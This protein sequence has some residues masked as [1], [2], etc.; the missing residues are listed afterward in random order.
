MD[1]QPLQTNFLE[2][3]QG[4]Y[5]AVIVIIE[6]VENSMW[7]GMVEYGNTLFHSTDSNT[8]HG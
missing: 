6:S 3:S 1:H 8:G 4:L 2:E 5:R 7:N